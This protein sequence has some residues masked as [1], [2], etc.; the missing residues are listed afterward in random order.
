MKKI[1]LY[2]LEAV[3]AILTYLGTRRT[4]SKRKQQDDAQD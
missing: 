2:V 1:V 3:A 4:E